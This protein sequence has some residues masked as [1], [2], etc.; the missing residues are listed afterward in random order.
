MK[1]QIRNKNLPDPIS[2]RETC[3]ENYVVIEINNPSIL[4]KTLHVS[5][6]MRK[7]SIVLDL[8]K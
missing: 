3:S 6:L 8:L 4:K 1:N 7:F 5:I 2:N